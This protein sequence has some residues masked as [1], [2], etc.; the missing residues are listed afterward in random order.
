MSRKKVKHVSRRITRNNEYR[1]NKKGSQLYNKSPK[2]RKASKYRKS[3]K[4][5]KKRSLP[6]HLNDLSPF[7]IIHDIPF[8]PVIPI[9]VPNKDDYSKS[10]S[11]TINA[12]LMSP[13]TNSPFVLAGCMSAD[14]LVK[15]KGDGEWMRYNWKGPN[16]KR[17][18]LGNLRSKKAIVCSDIVAPKQ[19][20]LNCW[21]N[22]FF[23]IFFI[24]DAG[25]KF[26]HWMREAMI[27]GKIVNR[28]GSTP[29]ILRDDLREPLFK[30]NNY[31]EASIRNGSDPENFADK[32]D[33]NE[34]IGM[35]YDAIGEEV[36]CEGLNNTYI[37]PVDMYGNPINFYNG[38]YY[39]IGGNNVPYTSLWIDNELGYTDVTDAVEHGALEGHQN[40]V[41]EMIYI[42]IDEID[43]IGSIM[44][45]KPTEF[46]I[47]IISGGDIYTCTYKLDSAILRS[48]HWEHFSSY[49]TC[50][51]TELGSDGEAEDRLQPFEWKKRLNDKTAGSW[52]LASDSEI[53]F[54]FTRGYQ[55]LV[56]YL[57][58]KVINKTGIYRECTYKTV[59]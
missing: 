17:V 32:M 2:Y 5:R 6:S 50:N 3:S 42:E 7:K 22:A 51:G 8:E 23:L 11:P 48:V 37:D 20:K 54:D 12:N 13:I 9:H 53:I 49:I 29:S 34:I 38:L 26:N 39:V 15:D 44:F 31:I 10:I 28:D 57:K 36:N 58:R 40:E 19:K 59:S 56:Y 16:A 47:D 35:I 14:I 4:S 55:I 18:M 1:R 52:K 43:E 25:R 33:T 41:Y 24:S 27:T 21:F 30:L 45:E 46:T